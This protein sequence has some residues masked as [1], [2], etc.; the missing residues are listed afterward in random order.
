MSL[1]SK[2]NLFRQKVDAVKKDAKNPFYRSNYATL[3]SVM[4]TIEPALNELKINYL[5]IIDNMSLKTIVYDVDNEDDKIESITPLIIAEN[6]MQKLGSAITYA[7]RYSLVTIFNL[8]QEDDDGNKTLNNK[9]LA[10]FEGAKTVENDDLLE[11]IKQ[12]IISKKY[13]HTNANSIYG[14]LKKKNFTGNDQQDLTNEA[15]WKKLV[16]WFEKK[17]SAK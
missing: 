15:E 11:N 9:I 13:I 7:R 16:D 6:D 14:Y 1:K 3:E 10:T 4:G 8:E 2:L 17:N 5:Q 12:Y